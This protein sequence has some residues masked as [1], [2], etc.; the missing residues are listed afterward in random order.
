MKLRH[1]RARFVR[2]HKRARH[3][4]FKQWFT[5]QFAKINVNGRFGKISPAPGVVGS[6][7]ASLLLDNVGWWGKHIF[8]PNL[9]NLT[10]EQNEDL[11]NYYAGASKIHAD[12]TEK[13]REWMREQLLDEYRSGL[14]SV[15]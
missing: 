8:G 15:K 13:L 1:R 4:N 6:N 7:P 12:N 2:N 3:F 11:E 5:R 14:D 10:P 9:D